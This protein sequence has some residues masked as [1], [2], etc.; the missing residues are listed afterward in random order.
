MYERIPDELKKLDRWVCWRIEDRDGK[1]TKVPINPISGSRAMSNNPATWGCFQDATKATL[2]NIKGIGFMFDGDGI[3]GVDLDHC[4]DGTGNLTDEARDIIGTLDSYTEY[5]QSGHGVHIICNGK[6]PE[7]RK[8]KGNVEMYAAGR[9]FVMTGTALDDGHTEV[10]DRTEE[11][12]EVHAKYLAEKKKQKRAPAATQDLELDDRSLIEKAMAAENGSRFKALYNGDTSGNGKDDSAA[13]LAFCNMLA[14]WTQCN[15]SQMDSIFRQSGLM[16]DKWDERHG[17]DTYGNITIHKAI[18]DCSKVYE[19]RQKK[20]KPTTQEAPEA[21]NGLDALVLGSSLSEQKFYRSTDAGNAE[22]LADYLRKNFIFVIENRAWAKFNGTNWENDGS[23]NIV[24]EAVKVFRL[25]AQK[26][27]CIENENREKR[28]KWLLQSESQS[29]I[30][31]ALDILSTINGMSCSINEFDTDNYLL[32]C[33]NGIVDLKTGKLLPHDPK[34][35]MMKICNT[36]YD[37]E[38]RSSFF[39]NFLDEIMLSKKD[40]VMF[41]QKLF[42]YVLTGSLK[43]EGFYIFKGEGGNGKSKLVESFVYAAGNYCTSS[44]PDVVMAKEKT[45]IPQDIARLKGARLIVLS[46]PDRNKKF[47]DNLF[48]WLTGNDTVNARFL[49]GREF[50]FKMTGKFILMTNHDVKT[51]STDNG[52]WRRMVKIPFDYI[53][54]EDKKDRDL[55]DKLKIQAPAIL[56]WAVKGCLLWQK[57]GLKPTEPMISATEEYKKS[58]DVVQLFLDECTQIVGAFHTPKSIFYAAFKQWCQDN[59][60]FEITQR[61]F[62]NRMISKSFTEKRLTGGTRAWENIILLSSFSDKVTQRTD[63]LES[64]YVKNRNKKVIENNATCINVSL[65]EDELDKKTRAMM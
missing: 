31:A 25:Q 2:P 64:R 63:I 3:I 53:V 48:K 11:L 21:D 4:K 58:Q 14:F 32:N 16:R 49:Y 55:E 28:V 42:G 61:E 33:Q 1:P 59:S 20:I 47:S 23:K 15:S 6:M 9:F 19:P 22:M 30:Y 24:Q 7:G 62:S 18:V 27:I 37:P 17:A 8:R 51:M 35:L 54:P 26:A 46:E 40:N 43:E 56:S 44:S 12:A 65:D 13:D 57:E 39:E 5:S 29:R 52:T 36:Y 10:E 38:A 41:L 60:E 34:R 45:Q 50:E